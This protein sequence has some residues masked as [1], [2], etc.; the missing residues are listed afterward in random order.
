MENGA[1]KTFKLAAL[2]SYQVGDRIKVLNGKL[3]RQ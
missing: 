3:S 2:T 1:S